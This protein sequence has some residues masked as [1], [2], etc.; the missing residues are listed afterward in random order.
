MS[1]HPY[2]PQKGEGTGIIVP[3]R[4]FLRG[5]TASL[6]FGSAVQAATPPS[7]LPTGQSRVSYKKNH[8]VL[9]PGAQSR[10]HLIHHC[11]ACQ[12]CAAKCP[13]NVIQP[14]MTDLGVQGFLVPVL[15][16]DHGFCNYNCTICTQVCPTAALITI[17][18]EAEKHKLQIGRVVLLEENCVVLTQET[19]CGACAEHC[20]TGAVT[21]RPYG[22]PDSALTIPEI[23]VDLCVGCG[24]CENI[25][26]VKPYRAIYVEG[27]ERHGEAKLA[28]DPDAKQQEVRPDSFGF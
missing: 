26:P 17:G 5:V 22:S 15:K 18:S 23:D 14:S 24:A 21:M 9:P 1:P 3:R 16:F 28:Y 7:E 13:S 8:P 12:L 25:C 27:L 11:T 20:P 10:R 4:S 2:P 6:F 19:N